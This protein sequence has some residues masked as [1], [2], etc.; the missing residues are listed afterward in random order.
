MHTDDRSEDRQATSEYP[1]LK[2]DWVHIRSAWFIGLIIAVTVMTIVLGV[3][4]ETTGSGNRVH[5]DP[6]GPMTSE[7]D[8][9][10]APNVPLGHDA[11]EPIEKRLEVLSEWLNQRLGTLHN[12]QA[13]LIEAVSALTEQDAKRQELAATLGEMQHQHEAGTEELLTRLTGLSVEVQKLKPLTPPT[14]AAGRSPSRPAVPPFQIDAIDDWDGVAYVAI[15]QDGQVAFLREGESRAGWTLV[16]LLPAERKVSF[17]GPKGP[18][19][20]TY[21]TTVGR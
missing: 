2:R 1:Q 3:L 18:K 17:K 20:Q 13:N 14:I 19:G 10:E 12:R 16:E 5:A 6:I 15:N 9:P 4:R 8:V 11:L 21:S 7:V